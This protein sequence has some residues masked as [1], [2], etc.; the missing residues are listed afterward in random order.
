MGRDLSWLNWNDEQWA[1]YRKL[2]S[3]RIKDVLGILKDKIDESDDFGWDMNISP[4]VVEKLKALLCEQKEHEQRIAN[5]E[6]D[7]RDYF[8]NLHKQAKAMKSDRM[9]RG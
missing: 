6:I 9:N 4:V 2:P 5:D 1:E 3:K 8:H 7:H